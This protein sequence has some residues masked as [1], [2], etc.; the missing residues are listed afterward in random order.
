MLLDIIDVKPKDNFLLFLTFENGEKKEFDCKPL[1]DK[2]V[3]KP[4]REKYFFNKAKVLYG[5]VV[6][7]DEIDIS[8]ETLYIDSKK[9]N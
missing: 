7:N 2:K 8:P 4:L 9:I 5:T 6:W 3:F 1:F